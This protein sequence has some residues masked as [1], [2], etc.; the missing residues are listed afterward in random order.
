[1]LFR[2][3]LLDKAV[4][5]E[6]KNAVNEIADSPQ[7]G[8]T[9]QD[10]LRTFIRDW[11]DG[12]ELEYTEDKAGNIIFDRNAVKR[13]RNVAPT[14]I[15]VN[16]NYETAADNAGLLACAAAVAYADLDSSRKTVVFVNNEQ[17]LAEGYRGLSSKYLSDKSKVIY[18]DAGSSSYQIGRAHV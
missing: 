1:M 16:M 13:K 7:G 9:S 10:E 2:S 4:Y 15:C 18:L 5:K 14:L 8:F 12:K 17:D 11:A 3:R 6:F